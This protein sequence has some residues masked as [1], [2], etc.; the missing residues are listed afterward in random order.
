[1]NTFLIIDGLNLVRRIHAAQPNEND[2]NGLDNRVASA[3]KKL[4]KFHQPSHAAIVW[5]GN[6]I[7]WR[8]HLFEDYKKG[9]KPMPKALSEY[10]PSLKLHLA[11]IHVN[12]LD[13][14]SEADDVIATLASKLA[15][16]G[17]EAIIVSTDKGFTQLNHPKIK[18]WD[19]FNKAY[20]TVEEREQKLGV[21]HSQF[22]DY[23]ALAGDSGNK[24]PGVPGIGPKSAI[25]LLKIFRSLANI[26]LSIDEVGAKQAKKLEEGKQMAR[27]SYKLV[28][29]Q[30]DMP[31]KANLSQFR[32]PQEAVSS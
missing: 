7:S 23:L 20:L 27:L 13:A 5:D 22:I 2:T 25:E 9:R 6:E 32:L 18:R 30:T 26:Y 31:L 19:H 14:N 11:K 17:G 24:I 16:S 28:Q 3:C 12:S 21:Q 1:M 15:A 10:L 29:L 8:K 4:L